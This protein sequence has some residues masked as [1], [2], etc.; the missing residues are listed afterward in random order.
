MFKVY[1]VPLIYLWSIVSLITIV[2]LSSKYVLA[3]YEIMTPTDLLILAYSIIYFSRSS[4][5]CSI[6]FGS[7]WL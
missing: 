5:F 7:Y 2:C 1:L 6:L 4:S 3:V